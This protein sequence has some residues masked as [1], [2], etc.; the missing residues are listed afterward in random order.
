MPRRTPLPPELL[1]APFHLREADA[2]GVGRSRLRGADLTAPFRGVRTAASAPDLVELCHT[3]ATRMP[4]GHH[5]SDVTAARLWGI[6]LPPETDER[7]HVTAPHPEREPRMRGTV[8][9]RIAATIDMR[10]LH[11][12]PVSSPCDTW[13]RL[14]TVLALD[15]LIAAGDRLLGW[16]KPLATTAEL[17]EALRRFGRRRG[18]RALHAARAEM[19]PGSGSPKETTLRLAAT[20]AGFPEPEC[21]GEIP[22][23]DGD[24]TW[25]DLVYRP[26]RVVFE[27]DGEDHRLVARRYRR[28]VERLNDLALA[29]WIVVRVNKFNEMDV[30]LRWLDRALR[31]RGWAGPR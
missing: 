30:A 8:G 29:G 1:L 26:W 15:D 18:S 7:V 6:P 27:W 13:C 11:A 14:G 16:P 2:L 24:K 4:Q 31:S 20:R 22:L 23:N 19:R 17:G 21:N 25:G 3:Y 9:H 12:L 5:F 28:D 10:F